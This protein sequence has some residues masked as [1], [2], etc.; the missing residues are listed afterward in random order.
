MFSGL[1][2]PL[3]RNIGVKLGLWYALIFALSS[4][5]LFMLAYYLLAAALGSKDREVLVAQ[6]KEAATVYENG[7]VRA[8]TSWVED[9]PPQVRNTMLVRIENR[10]THLGLVIHTPP[11]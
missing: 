5:A 8:L 2:D 1:L 9:Q 11:D 10:F 3:R 4:A 6:L 7:G